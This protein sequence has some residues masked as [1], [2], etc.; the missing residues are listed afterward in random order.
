MLCILIDRGVTFVCG[1]GFRF[2]CL[3]SC[4][5]SIHQISRCHGCQ[6][7]FRCAGRG[8]QT[9]AHSWPYR[10]CD[11]ADGCDG[12]AVDSGRTVAFYSAA[13]TGAAADARAVGAGGFDDAAGDGDVAAAATGDVAIAAANARAATAG[14]DNGAAVNGDVAAVAAAA[15]TAAAANTRAHLVAGGG[16]GAAINGDVAAASAGGTIAAADARTV[17]AGGFD[18]TAVDGDVAAGDTGGNVIV[19]AD[20][21]VTSD[22]NIGNQ[23]AGALRLTVYGQGVGVMHLNARIGCQS[24]AILKDQ[25]YIAADGDAAADRHFAADHI[26]TV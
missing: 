19:A 17:G 14:G 6:T 1:A 20:G 4:I 3:I 7:G 10:K 25:V 5:C 11:F 12:A 9:V 24:T 23:L 13:A 16:N 8:F 15:S 21:R 26:P 2:Y 18:G 22:R